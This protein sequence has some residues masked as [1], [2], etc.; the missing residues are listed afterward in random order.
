MAYERANRTERVYVRITEKQKAAI[1]ARAN[2]KGLTISEYI[3]YLVLHDL[4]KNS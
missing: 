1:L 2:E 3:R 4:E